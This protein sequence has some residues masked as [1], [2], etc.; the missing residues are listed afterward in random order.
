MQNEQHTPRASMLALCILLTPKILSNFQKSPSPP[1]SYPLRNRFGLQ[2]ATEAAGGGDAACCCGCGCALRERILRAASAEMRHVGSKASSCSMVL[3]SRRKMSVMMRRYYQ[4]VQ[5]G[6]LLGIW[7][8]DCV[9]WLQ[10]YVPASVLPCC[11]F[12][13]NGNFVVMSSHECCAPQLNM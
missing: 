6:M 5:D 7:M 4:S 1:P 9:R 2:A 12:D 11:K 8:S 3:R 13:G 10:K